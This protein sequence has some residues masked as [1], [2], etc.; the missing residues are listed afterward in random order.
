MIDEK[1]FYK[2]QSI[3]DDDSN[4]NHTIDNLF[5]NQFYFNNPT[6]LNDPLDS[7]VNFVFKGKEEN[8]VDF[9]IEAGIDPTQIETNIQSWLNNGVIEKEGDILIMTP[10][11]IDYQNLPHVCCFSETDDNMAMWSHYAH[12]HQGICLRFRSK[13]ESDGYFLNLHST[14]KS[15]RSKFFKIRYSNSHSFT[16]NKLDEDISKKIVEFLL[17]KHS[18]WESEKEYRMVIFEDNLEGGVI[19]YEK[20]DLEGITFGLK[21]KSENVKRIYSTIDEKYLKAGLEVNFYEAKEI[22]DG[23]KIIKINDIDSYL[24]HL[25]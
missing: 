18:D 15:I 9:L 12:N 3:K 22:G 25:T 17:I 1:I 2:Y 19:R 16:I 8:L 11:K 4:S 23:I 13:Q 6:K 7:K 20:E 14:F 21:I 24:E 5:K 10:T